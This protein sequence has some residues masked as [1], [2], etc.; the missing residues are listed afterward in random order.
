MEVVGCVY[1][2]LH[3]SESRRPQLL[4]VPSCGKAPLQARLDLTLETMKMRTTMKVALRDKPTKPKPNEKSNAMQ[5]LASGIPA[6]V[7]DQ[8]RSA[9]L[10]TVLF[11]AE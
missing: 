11:K 6:A 3:R 7:Q 5:E 9:G 2:T 10:A 8:P 1:L 4:G